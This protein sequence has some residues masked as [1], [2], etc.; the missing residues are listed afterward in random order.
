MSKG[1][2]QIWKDAIVEGDTGRLDCLLELDGLDDGN[3]YLLT[4]KAVRSG[5]CS[6]V[7]WLQ[8]NKHF[9]LVLSEDMICAVRKNHVDVVKNMIELK[10]CVLENNNFIM[11]LLRIACQNESWKIA[12]C[13]IDNYRS[14]ISELQD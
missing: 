9:D 14:R 7:E 2:L 1:S 13:I 8:K 10:I 12:T 4:S 5:S 6:S 3:N 11:K